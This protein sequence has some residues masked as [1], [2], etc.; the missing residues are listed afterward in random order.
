MPASDYLENEILDHIFSAATWAAD[1]TIYVG[2]STV[3][4]TDSD[5]GSTV[6]EP[7]ASYAR[8]AVTN[9][10]TEWPASSGG[11]KAN[12]NAISFPTPGAG[13]WGL[14]TDFFIASAASAGNIY[15]YGTLTIAKTI[16]QNDTVQFAAN[17][18]DLTVT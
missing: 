4:I 2:L 7:A 14:I 15:V 8:V 16:N 3:T 17:D 1:A 9:N 6:T 10:A 5:T 11:T 13:G 18:L 12:A